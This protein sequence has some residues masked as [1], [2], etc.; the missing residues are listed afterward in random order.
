LAFLAIAASPVA[1]G[2][3]THAEAEAKVKE[4]GVQ[5]QAH[6]ASARAKSA[7]GQKALQ[8]GDRTTACTL[9]TASRAETDTVLGLLTQQREQIML[10]TPDAATSIGRANGID[11]QTGAWMTLAGQLDQRVAMACGS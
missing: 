5:L 7:E 4:L 9:Y 6:S 2:Q 3:N 10:A 11:G 1:F 8:A